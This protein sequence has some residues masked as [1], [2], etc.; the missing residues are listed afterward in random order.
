[1]K[2]KG[3]YIILENNDNDIVNIDNISTIENCNAGSKVK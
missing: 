2:I 3:N 1:M